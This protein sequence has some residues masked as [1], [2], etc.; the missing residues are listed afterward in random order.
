MLGDKSSSQGF[1]RNCF[2]L[3]PQNT[4]ARVSTISFDVAQAFLLLAVCLLLLFASWALFISSVILPLRFG[5]VFYATTTEILLIYRNY[6]DEFQSS[7]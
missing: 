1:S 3:Q 4:Q 5:A 2:R 6:M 7:D